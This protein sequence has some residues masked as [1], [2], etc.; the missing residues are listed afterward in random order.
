MKAPLSKR[1]RKILAD[2][3]LSKQLM[4]AILADRSNVPDEEK[5]TIVVDGEELK[6]VRVRSL[7]RSK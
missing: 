2:N 3:E 6:L 5:P 1:V 7:H 4:K